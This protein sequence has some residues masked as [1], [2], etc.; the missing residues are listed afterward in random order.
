M[1][2]KEIT[3]ETETAD[4][5]PI[6]YCHKV[7][8]K[9]G[10]GSTVQLQQAESYYT[11]IFLDD[12]QV[13]LTLLDFQDKPTQIKL[14]MDKEE[15]E[16]EYAIVPDYF[17]KKKT[18]DDIKEAKHVAL[19]DRHLQ[20]KEYFSAEYEYDNAIAVKPTSVRGNY[21][22]GKALLERGEIDEAEKIFE[23]LSEKKELYGK[24]YKHIFNSLGIDLRKMGKLDEAIRNYKRAIYMDAEDEILHYNI[25][26]V[27]Y[28]MGSPDEAVKHLTKALSIN[29]S[30]EEGKDFLSN[31]KAG[32]KY[33]PSDAG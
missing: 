2:E 7:N 10:T 1:S 32:A 31:I 14:V 29:P 12:D 9:L 8:F 11:A 28:L 26:H 15:L 13:Q 33:V 23:K 24:K 4:H 19:A 6:V 5:E 21:G 17:S 20:K 27:Y 3:P 16:A 22:K 30:F 25:A 18:P